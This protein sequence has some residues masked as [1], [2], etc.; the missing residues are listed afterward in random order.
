MIRCQK[1]GY[2]NQ[3]TAKKCIKCN[4]VLGVEAAPKS[5]DAD[6]RTNSDIKFEKT[7]WD[8]PDREKTIR[9]V[10]YTNT[11]PCSLVQLTEDGE[12]EGKVIPVKGEMVNLNRDLLDEG[13]TSISR[14]A[15][16]T[17]MFKDGE[18]WVSNET[19]KKTT[20]LQVNRSVKLTDGDVIL[21][22]DTM[23]KFSQ[24]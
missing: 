5:G 12:E 16:A 23:F 17:L 13:N 7:P 11:K 9:R 19:D 15:H 3:S 10:N 14:K 22:G 18:W 24:K 20:F 2:T 21:L 1:C 8:K 6:G 4:N